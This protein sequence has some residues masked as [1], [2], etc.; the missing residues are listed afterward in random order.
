MTVTTTSYGTWNNR[1][2]AY[3]LTVEQTV[4]EA[5]GDAAD[6]FDHEAIADDYRRAINEALPSG[7]ALTGDEFIGPWEAGDEF[8]GY[9]TD[10]FGGLDIAAIVQS[11]DLWKIAERYDLTTT[12]YTAEVGEENAQWLAGNDG[13]TADLEPQDR[14]TDLG[15][16]KVRIPGAAIPKL[17][18]RHDYEDGFVDVDGV[19]RIW[20][21]DTDFPLTPDQHDD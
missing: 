4:Y 2:D 3:A 11:I 21:D 9:P 12:S 8:D 17:R 6:E 13:P 7:V 1:I 14:I 10:E 15:S 5:L 16:G 18:R 19:L 20:I